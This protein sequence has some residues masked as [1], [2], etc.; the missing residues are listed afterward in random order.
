MGNLIIARNES[1]HKYIIPSFQKPET[2]NQFIAYT[3]QYYK[4]PEAAENRK[5][6]LKCKLHKEYSS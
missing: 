4:L 5:H 1:D 6:D 3:G 2:H